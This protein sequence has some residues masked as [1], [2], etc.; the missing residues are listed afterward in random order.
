MRINVEVDP[1]AYARQIGAFHTRNEVLEFVTDVDAAVAETEFTHDLI[2]RLSGSISE[3]SEVRGDD[4]LTVPGVQEGRKVSFI[5]LY[6]GLSHMPEEILIALLANA[7][8]VKRDREAEA[9]RNALIC[10]VC[11]HPAGVHNEPCLPG[12]VIS[13]HACSEAAKANVG[14]PCGCP[15]RSH[16]G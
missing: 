2:Y 7:M 10:Q 4:L 6:E 3:E 9:A 13:C 16:E 1:A 5:Q 15:E 14:G 8:M 11:E 12:L